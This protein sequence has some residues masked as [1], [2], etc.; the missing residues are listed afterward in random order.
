MK[1]VFV[2]KENNNSNNNEESGGM[3]AVCRNNTGR[4]E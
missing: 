4:H 1:M 3:Y 2:I